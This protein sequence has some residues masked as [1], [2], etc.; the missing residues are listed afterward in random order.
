MHKITARIAKLS[1]AWRWA[2]MLWLAA[3]IFLT[4][5]ALGVWAAQIPIFPKPTLYYEIQPV[6]GGVIEPL[7]GYW[8]RWDAI[9]YQRIV[10]NGYSDQTSVFFPL[11]PLAAGLLVCLTGMGS[12]AALLVVSNL[13]TLV[14]LKVLYEITQEDYGEATARTA[15][16]VAV[17]LPTGFFLFAPFPN[18]LSL[19]LILLAYQAARRNQFLLASLLGIATGLTHGTGI[20][21]AL[22]LA[23]ETIRALRQPNKK[24]LHWSILALPLTPLMGTAVFMAWRYAQGLPSYAL[25]QETLWVRG[26]QWPWVSLVRVPNSLLIP[27]RQF[28][29]WADFLLFGLTI[30]VMVWGWKRL[31]WEQWGFLIAALG[32][33]FSAPDHIAPLVGYGRY[34]LIMFP[35]F[36][37]LAKWI[38]GIRAKQLVWIPAVV[39]QFLL[40][41]FYFMWL[42]VE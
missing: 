13:A 28:S 1:P 36:I 18:A 38:N 7:L 9:H 11:Y 16:V 25:V 12:L 41:S 5:W 19:M 31:K 6:E 23:N 34:I 24:L 26:L 35:L 42:W 33:M 39:A 30:A 14:A 40:L 29:G 2:I 15:A 20:P 32:L 10:E 4:L 21:L 37:G 3:R 22:L 27:I 17:L 8:Q